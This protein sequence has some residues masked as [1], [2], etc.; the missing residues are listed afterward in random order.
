MSD[1]LIDVAAFDALTPPAAGALLRPSCAST[2]WVEA[3]VTQRPYGSLDAVL[4]RSDAVLADCGW[5]DLEQALA[6]H[7]R[8]GERSVGADREAAWSRDE[9]SG[10][11]RADADADALRAGNV[12]YEQRFGYV[13]LIC[14]TGR[15]SAQ[16][17][18]A[19]RAR[20][21]ND[22]RAERE[23]IRAELTAIVRLRLAKTLR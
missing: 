21:G 19:L 3:M 5:A 10:T 15:T 18:D 2:A 23:V 1:A 11:D 16:L 7:P 22:A 12:E 14:A 4:V 20:L 9:Q 13:F 17:L 8:I 6:A